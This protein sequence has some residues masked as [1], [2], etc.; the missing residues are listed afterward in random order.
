MKTTKKPLEPSFGNILPQAIDAEKAVLSAIIGFRNAYD[1][2]AFLA[3]AMFYDPRH[4]D[5]FDTIVSMKK[6]N[7]AID[8]LT[9]TDEIAA[10]GKMEEITMWYIADLSTFVVSDIH[11]LEHALI[12]KQKY[13]QRQLI[14]L[15]MQVQSNAYTGTEDIG[16]L[17]FDTGKQIECLME[18]LV[19]QQQESSYEDISR[20][21]Y[22]DLQE[23]ISRYN[24]NQQTGVT[25]GLTELDNIT[26]G[27]QGS[28]LIILAARPAMGKTA[29]ALH[30]ATSAARAGTPVLIFSLEMSKVS[31]YQRSVL[32]ES[33]TISAGHLKSGNID[34]EELSH[35]DK[36]V[37]RLYQLPIYVDDN[38]NLNMASIRAKC[39]LLHKQKKCGMVIIDYLQ[40]VTPE[41]SRT[42]NREQEISTMSREAKLLAKEL[43]VP[44]ILLSQL[45]RDLEKRHN[46]QPQLSDLRESGAIE[47]D[48]DMVVFVHRPGYY[49]Q[50]ITDKE[51][52]EIKNAGELIIAKYRNGPVGKVKFRHNKT[53]TRI[54]DFK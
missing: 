16:D 24:S 30:L 40:L 25:T 52:N 17:L 9:I 7:K 23:R 6:K 50:V 19:G 46:K 26:S 45:N 36:S 51:G 54:M 28:E 2:V 37:A 3:P 53:L 33:E 47:Q 1:E 15:T 12:V 11:I 38:A 41:K 49:G 4:R 10:R 29:V 22:Q 34:S 31:L 35:I 8:L 43:D 20:L 42:A 18:T 44:V 21:F 32:S 13:L 14:E 39:R 27:W 5:I 48:A